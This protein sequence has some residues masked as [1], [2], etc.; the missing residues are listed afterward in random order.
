MTRDQ[1]LNLIAQAVADGKVVRLPYMVDVPLEADDR[2]RF[3]SLHRKK[4]HGQLS[5]QNR[6]PVKKDTL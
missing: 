1:E 2:R 4:A 6:R 5:R 3:F